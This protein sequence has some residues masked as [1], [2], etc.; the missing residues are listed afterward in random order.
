MVKAFIVI[1]PCMAC[2]SLAG[3]CSVLSGTSGHYMLILRLKF[4]HFMPKLCPFY[5]LLQRMK[6]PDRVRSWRIECLQNSLFYCQNGYWFLFLSSWS[7]NPIHMPLFSIFDVI[8]FKFSIWNLPNPSCNK[9]EIYICCFISRC[10]SLQAPHFEVSK[11]IKAI[12]GSC[13][14]KR[15]LPME[16]DLSLVQCPWFPQ[17]SRNLVLL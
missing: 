1:L 2:A 5:S 10:A 3:I 14:L 16:L 6:I 13:V 4:A 11:P 12:P 7:L 15:S 17:V 8:I 9:T